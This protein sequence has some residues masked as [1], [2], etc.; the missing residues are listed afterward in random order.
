[1]PA[2]SSS[3]LL[4]RRCWASSLD[5]ELGAVELELL[6]EVQVLPV[7]ESRLVEFGELLGELRILALQQVD[8]FLA[9]RL[10]VGPFAQDDPRFA[11]LED[12]NRLARRGAQ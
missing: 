2:S 9:Q 12:N 10:D 6:V 7:R 4:I 3:R 8:A 1:M 5:V 11:I